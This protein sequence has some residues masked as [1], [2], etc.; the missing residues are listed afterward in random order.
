MPEVKNGE[1]MAFGSAKRIAVVGCVG[2]GKSTVARTLGEMLDLEVFHLDRL[3][4][5]GGGY[6]I[7]GPDTAASHA[8]DDKA[9]RELQEELISRDSWIIDGGRADLDLRL[10]RAGVVVFLDLPR[11]TCTWR[12]IKRTGRPRADYPPDV[13]ESWRWMWVLIRWVWTYPRDKRTGMLLSIEEY[14]AHAKL[15]HC[16]SKSDVQHLLEG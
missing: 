8:M 16:R 5:Q 7:I 4:W 6:R 12:I 13:K 9:F 3:W 2:A 1:A 14:A 11:R 10:A 15:I